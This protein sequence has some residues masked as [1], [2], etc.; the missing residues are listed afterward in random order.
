MGYLCSAPVY[1]F[2]FPVPISYWLL[3]LLE[4]KRNTLPHE[5][6]SQY[7]VPNVFAIKAQRESRN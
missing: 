5:G 4:C 7:L 1:M 6:V 3:L 2:Q